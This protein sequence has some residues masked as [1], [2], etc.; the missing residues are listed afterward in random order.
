VSYQLKNGREISAALQGRKGELLRSVKSMCPHYT[1]HG[2][3]VDKSSNEM[4]V[5]EVRWAMIGRDLPDNYQAAASFP[6]G[7]T[8]FQ[9][10]A[11]CGAR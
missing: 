10:N 11:R 9:R 2:G 7:P 3:T 6:S 1:G 4:L 5:G 8:T